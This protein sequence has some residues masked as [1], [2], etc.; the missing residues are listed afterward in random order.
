MGSY[1]GGVIG[2]EMRPI[3]N[4]SDAFNFLAKSRDDIAS[5]LLSTAVKLN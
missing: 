5:I 3:Y 1:A 2:G 4:W